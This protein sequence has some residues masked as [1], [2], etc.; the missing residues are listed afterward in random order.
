MSEASQD[1]DNPDGVAAGP[2]SARAEAEAVTSVN[3]E[4][5]Q[6]QE[7][8]LQAEET[9][10]PG[11]SG[12]TSTYFAKTIGFSDEA[13]LA[14]SGRSKCH[15]CQSPISKGSPRFP[16]HYHRLRPFA[17]MH[18]SCVVPFVLA[19]P[20][21]RREQALAVLTPAQ[22]DSRPL[23]AQAAAQIVEQLLGHQGVSSS[24][25]AARDRIQ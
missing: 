22:H 18:A 4:I 11:R 24:A 6:E 20:D 1:S 10:P 15:H 9:C 3:V 13:D 21:T 14:K 19:Q 17:W 5:L 16:Y 25:S 2:S 23:L 7:M 8:Q 12:P